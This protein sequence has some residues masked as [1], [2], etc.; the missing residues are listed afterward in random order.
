MSHTNCRM[1]EPGLTHKQ[2]E[3]FQAA[4]AAFIADE[5]ISFLSTSTAE[6][7]GGEDGEPC[8]L[9]VTVRVLWFAP[10]RQSRVSICPRCQQWHCAVHDL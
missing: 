6:T 10:G 5:G 7:C 9:M 8:V 4:V 2:Y 3:D 1:A